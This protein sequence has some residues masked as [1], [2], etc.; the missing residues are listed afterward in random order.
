MYQVKL[1][2]SC[3]LVNP[4]VE[5]GG[6][7][8]KLVDIPDSVVERIKKDAVNEYILSKTPKSVFAEK[9][10]GVKPRWYQRVLLRLR[11]RR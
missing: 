3:K 8:Y 9:F 11:G 10:F 2:D 7:E 1:Y 5:L 4:N 6:K